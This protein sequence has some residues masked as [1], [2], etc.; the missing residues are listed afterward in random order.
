[1]SNDTV[2]PGTYL[3]GFIRR[4]RRLPASVGLIDISHIQNAGDQYLACHMPFEQSNGPLDGKTDAIQYRH[5]L[6]LCFSD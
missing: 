4:L 1:M 3:S 5:I 2:L 6:P